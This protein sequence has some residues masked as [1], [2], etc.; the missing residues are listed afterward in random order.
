MSFVIFI[1]FYL[2][3]SNVLIIVRKY[4]DIDDICIYNAYAY[5]RKFIYIYVYAQMAAQ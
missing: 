4:D 1:S 3:M 2:Q 5:V